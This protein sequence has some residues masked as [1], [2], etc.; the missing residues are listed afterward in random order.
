MMEGNCDAIAPVIIIIMLFFNSSQETGG[1]L[2]DRVPQ[3]TWAVAMG[4]RYR[5]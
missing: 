3:A 4:V 5:R 2:N 1:E